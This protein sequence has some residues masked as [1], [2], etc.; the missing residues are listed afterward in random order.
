M[1]D[2]DPLSLDFAAR[3]PDLFARVVGRGDIDECARI[4]E[5]LPPKRKAA[6]VARLPAPRIMHLLESTEHDPAQW[7]ADAPFDDA[8]TLL[9]RIPRERR[10]ALINSLSD[11]D[12][13]R[14][15]LRHQQY[16]AHSVG[17]LVGDIPLRLDAESVV[18]DVVA[19]LRELDSDAQGPVVIVD[20]DGR[21]LGVLDRWRLLM[22]S[23]PTGQVQDYLVAV[24]AVRPETP[25]TTVALDEEWHTRN[26]LPVIDNRYRVLGIVSREK[27]LRAAGADAVNAGGAS[28]VLIDLLADLVYVCDAVLVKALSRRDVK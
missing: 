19:E 1:V 5:N 8:V 20:A 21:Y 24:K 12:R 7:L 25:V 2:I 14:R 17:A 27:V 3:H 9:S 13:Q 11:R 28:D 23:Q 22:R 26:W 15:L 4:I 10:L 16:P 18:A 6:I